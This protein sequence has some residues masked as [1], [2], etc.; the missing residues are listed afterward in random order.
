LAL[1]Q[2]DV[3]AD[4]GTPTPI[5]QPYSDN[6]TWEQAVFV[7]ITALQVNLVSRRRIEGLVYA[8]YLGSLIANTDTPRTQWRNFTQQYQ[9]TN[10]SHYRNGGLRVYQLFRDRPNQMYQSRRISFNILN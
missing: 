6:D 3:T 9:I 8:F 10:A 7:T 1:L 4:G 5:N 2:L